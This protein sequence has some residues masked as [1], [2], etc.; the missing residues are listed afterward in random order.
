[1]RVRAGCLVA[2][3]AAVTVGLGPGTGLAAAGHAAVAQAVRPARL[4]I[5]PRQARGFT[6]VLPALTI[7]RALTRHSACGTVHAIPRHGSNTIEA[8][9]RPVSISPDG[10]TVTLDVLF[11]SLVI[12]PGVR[13][14][15]QVYRSTLASAR[16]C[17][18]AHFVPSFG[19]DSVDVRAHTS[20]RALTGIAHETRGYLE[21]LHIRGSGTI[22]DAA[23]SGGGTTQLAVIER[24][25]AVIQLTL[26]RVRMTTDS[27]GNPTSLALL[28]G[29]RVRA[30]FRRLLATAVTDAKL[31]TAT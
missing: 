28:D 19:T 26:V 20:V 14:A 30:A 8:M 23:V 16:R 27:A 5:T 9:F 2:V 22:N 6:T 7:T 15:D 4:V 13:A 11:E 10:A 25:R 1:V 3:T 17:P 12:G 29:P 18:N 31:P 24:G 21:T